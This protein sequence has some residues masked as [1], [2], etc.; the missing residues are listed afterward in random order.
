VTKGIVSA[1]R[2]LDG[3]SY[4]QSDVTVNPGNSGGPLL[5]ANRN[6]IGMTVSGLDKSGVPLGS[7]LFIPIKDAEDFLA[8]RA[9][10]Q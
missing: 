10:S 8:M 2:V 9:T 6:V 3:L 1:N 4:I 7:N 5:D